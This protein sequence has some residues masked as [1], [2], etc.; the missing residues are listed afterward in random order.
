[1]NNPLL[2]EMVEDSLWLRLISLESLIDRHLDNNLLY[3]NRHQDNNQFYK[4]FN[5]NPCL[6]P[7][8]SRF[9]SS[10]IL[11]LSL[12]IATT[13]PFKLEALTQNS[14]AWLK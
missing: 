7:F 8:L 2:E 14:N 4:Q 10:L 1:M 13:E 5:H 12:L 9:L 11:L 3:I 6:Y